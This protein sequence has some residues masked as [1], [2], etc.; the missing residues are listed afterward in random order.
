MS[1]EKKGG[2]RGTHKD[3]DLTDVQE[4]MQDNDLPTFYTTEDEDKDE[5]E[6]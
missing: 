5:A 3:N 2:E 6:D 1:K 4:I